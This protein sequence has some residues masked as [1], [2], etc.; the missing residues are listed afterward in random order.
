[1]PDQP[2]RSEHLAWAKQR[3]LEY[4]AVG[5][6]LQ[7]FTSMG[8]DLASHP[9]TANHAGLKLGIGILMVGGL[10]SPAEMK[11]FIEGFN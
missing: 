10:S 9:E 5:D 7:A 11:K 2:S 1:M 4:C 8:S 3:A 6:T